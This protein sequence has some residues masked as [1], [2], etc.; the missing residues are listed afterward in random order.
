[1]RKIS[2]VLLLALI[3]AAGCSQAP[4]EVKSTN[5]LDLEFG[6]VTADNE[7][8]G[9]GDA[10]LVAAAA[11]EVD[12]GDPLAAAIEADAAGSTGVHAVF[13]LRAVWGQLRYDSTSTAPTVWDGSV[14]VDS[15]RIGVRRLIRFEPEQDYVVLPRTAPNVVEFVSQTTVHN[16]GLL[17]LI[18]VNTALLA[19]SSDNLVTFATGPL[20]IS[21]RLRQLVLLDT[22]ISVDNAGN[23]VMFNG[24][25]V[26][27]DDCPKGFLGGQ[28]TAGEE[29]G[30]FKGRWISRDGELEGFL[31]G[32]Y[33]VNSEGRRV[34]FGKYIDADGNFEGRLR[35]V[36]GPA[37]EPI[38]GGF[39]MGVFYDPQDRPAG[40]LHGHWNADEPGM[41]SFEGVWMLHCPRWDMGG[42]AW[43]RW[44]DESFH[45]GWLEDD[46][47]L[48]GGM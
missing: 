32:T 38:R 8:P 29:G 5:P 42:R 26:R 33:G 46:R 36:W 15:G 25:L 41:G 47:P 22:L 17:L 44:D 3:F 30:E 2:L 12:P 16:D 48:G 10:G 4:T 34:F 24:F 9:F 18:G 13:A 11:V 39:F 35:G 45:P 40:R 31:M 23:A 27:P 6:G 28:W 14:K 20:T 43:D 7:A 1:M 19:D 21:F 37:P